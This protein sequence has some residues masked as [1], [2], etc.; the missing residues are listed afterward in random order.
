VT[1]N[2][3]P[4]VRKVKKRGQLEAQLE[5]QTRNTNSPAMRAHSHDVRGKLR[6]SL[7][8][9]GLACQCEAVRIAVHRRRAESVND[10]AASPFAH[11]L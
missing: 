6:P 1:P 7:L 2:R 11:T 9:D 10:I 4:D 8:I 3:C 5:G